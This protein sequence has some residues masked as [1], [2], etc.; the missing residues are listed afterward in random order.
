MM[1]W[2]QEAR[3]VDYRSES[4]PRMSLPNWVYNDMEDDMDRNFYLQ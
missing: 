4:S 3:I 2:A 1:T